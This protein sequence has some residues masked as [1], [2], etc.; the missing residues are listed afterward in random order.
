[1]RE[2]VF[3][4]RQSNGLNIPSPEESAESTSARQLLAIPAILAL[5]I[6][7]FKSNAMFFGTM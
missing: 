2:L 3:S 4:R 5:Y 1:M 7:V 6:N